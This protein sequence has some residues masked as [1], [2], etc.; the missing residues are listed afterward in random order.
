MTFDNMDP[1]GKEYTNGEITVV[2]KPRLCDHSAVCISELPSVFDSIKRPWIKM[3]AAPTE[4]I[5]K[6]VDRCPTAALTWYKNGEKPGENA[7]NEQAK[8]TIKLMKTGP[9]L[10]SG[11]FTLIDENGNNVTCGDKISICRCRKS[12]RMP[13]CDGTH[14]EEQ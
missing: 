3:T 4:D 5:K 6:V 12:K 11:S 9:L 10:V 13:F 14:R 1:V 7:K 2:W 8:T